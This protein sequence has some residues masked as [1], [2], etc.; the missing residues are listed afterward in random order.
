MPDPEK[1][2][3]DTGKTRYAIFVHLRTTPSWL[4]LPRAQRSA[5][6]AE[7][8][9]QAL[10]SDEVRM[11]Y[12]DAEAFTGRCT[13]LALFETTDLKAYYFAIERLRDTPLFTVPYFEVTDIIATVE[14]GY[15]AFEKSEETAHE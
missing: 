12:F 1:S 14:D 7:A 5:I 15:I 9:A 13:D 6:A 4:A 8:F 3:K 11:R 2:A 10:P